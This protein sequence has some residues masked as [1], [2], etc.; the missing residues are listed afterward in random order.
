M[1]GFLEKHFN[2]LSK[3][4]SPTEIE[5]AFDS[6]G[7]RVAFKRLALYIAKSYVSNALSKCEIK[8]YNSGEEVHDDLYYRLNVSPNPNQSGSQMFNGLV[9]NL[10][11]DSEA[12]IVPHRKKFLYVADSFTVDRQPLKDHMMRSIVVEGESYGKDMKASDV[13]YFRLDNERDG[14]SVKAIIDSL[15]KDYGLLIGAAIDGFRATRGRK[16]KLVLDQV[17]V[18]DEKFRQD[19]EGVVKKQLQDFMDN[20]NA[21]Y[22]QFQGYD[23]QEMKHETAGDSGDI[24][25]MRKEIFDTVAQAFKIPNSM[26]YG[27][28][29]NT[30]DVVNQFLTFAV[31]PIASMIS[32]ELTRKSFT[33]EEWRAGS[34]VVVD[35]KRI[36]HIDIFNVATGIEKLISSGT[37]SIDMVLENLGY[38]PLNTDFSSA[39]FITKNYSRAEDALNALDIEGGE[40]K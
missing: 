38:Q 2:F 33:F 31:D 1:A 35:T 37:F 18:G 40:T 14:L 7:E 13:Y 20:P 16:Y 28:M 25:A 19:Y 36:N 3:P 10:L 6:L 21:I 39:H 26:M 11:T 32:D 8:V 29:T 22:P 30:N 17:K 34:K 4:L 5:A 9:D 27:N 23:L 15:Y 24:I 12:M